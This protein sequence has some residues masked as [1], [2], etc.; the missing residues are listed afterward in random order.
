[1]GL[2][3]V[4]LCRMCGWLMKFVFCTTMRFIAY[5]RAMRRRDDAIYQNKITK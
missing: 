1:M 3:R 5:W 2:C 4:V